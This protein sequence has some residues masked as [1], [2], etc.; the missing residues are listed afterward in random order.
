MTE[1][2]ARQLA[3]ELLLKSE[4]NGAFSNLALDAVLSQATL[5]Q[6]D[7]S[8]ISALYYGVLERKITLDHIVS[9]Y[10]K[11]PIAKISPDVMNILRLGLYQLLYMNAVP[12]SAA[13]NES[14]NLV[15][16]VRKKSAKSFVNAILRQF[17][18]DGKEIRYPDA[19][20]S[21]IP[22]LSI[23]YSCP[24]WLVS[25]WLADYGREA[26]EQILSAS[27]GEPP[28]TLRVNTTKVTAEEL[29]RLLSEENVSA[30]PHPTVENCLILKKAGDIERLSAYRKGL[31][32]VQ[33]I[34]SQL[35]CMALDP[36]P[37]DY[38][39]DL[40]AAPGGTTFTIAILMENQGKLI[41]CDL[42]PKRTKL[43]ENG[44][45]RLGLSAIQAIPANANEFHPEFCGAD[46]V[47][48]DV[49]CAGLGVIRRKPEIKYKKPEELDRLPEI[50]YNILCNASNYVKT[51][52]RLVY[53]TCSLSKKENEQVVARFLES[54]P[55]F[56]L[57][58]FPDSF[59]LKRNA[60]SGMITLFP[61]SD[62]S[63]GFFIALL[64]KQHG[65]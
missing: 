23:V 14:V 16:T 20:K 56:S 32:H 62:G 48:C 2:S 50:Q 39:L 54:H 18:R 3:L 31:F 59:P 36:K 57:Q 52:G 38:V 5:E 44:A 63:D 19:D 10:S 9:Q 40:C 34:A 13:V 8:F 33:D 53:S 29:C 47:L 61:Q 6:R 43:V 41:A 65:E 12:D 7:K 49:P 30:K 15:E 28:I 4:C 55:A 22:Y 58:A 64:K 11:L 17:I 42:Y 51:D 1:K 60:E 26:T 37:K 24:E 21:P 35:C 27:L 46:C 25:Q 45:N